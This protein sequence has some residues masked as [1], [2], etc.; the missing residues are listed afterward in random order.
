MVL[1]VDSAGKVRSAK[2][3][4]KAEWTDEGFKASV[5]WK[6]IPAFKDDN[7]VASRINYAV[8]LQAMRIERR[9]KARR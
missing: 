8:S 5:S 1:V 3:E 2:P 4:D 7:P 9:V 6:F